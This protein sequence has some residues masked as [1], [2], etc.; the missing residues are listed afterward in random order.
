MTGAVFVSYSREDKVFVERLHAALLEAERDV[1]LD[2]VK[3]PPRADWRSELE[4]GI[5]GAGV[6]A[7]VISPDSLASEICMHELQHALA[8]G[9]RI[10]LL[11]RREPQA[12]GVPDA[13][14]RRQWIFV[15]KCDDF[16]AAFKGIV[17]EI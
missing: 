7:F 6:F 2:T 8:H 15:R 9:K 13:L 10:V 4:R 17:S 14:A 16:D 11:L 1:W 5:E 12:R 3:I